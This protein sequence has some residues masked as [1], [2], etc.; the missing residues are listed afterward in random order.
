[1][2]RTKNSADYCT[3]DVFVPSM[4]YIFANVIS[5]LK[6]S[7]TIPMSGLASPDQLWGCRW[8]LASVSVKD[9]F[10]LNG[11]HKYMNKDGRNKDIADVDFVDEH[12]FVRV[13]RKN[14]LTITMSV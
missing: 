5:S 4:K 8:G 11:W 9:H 14:R 10:G 1:M 7:E 2:H 6:C 13:L 3:A 12:S